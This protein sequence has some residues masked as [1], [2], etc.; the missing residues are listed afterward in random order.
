M[1]EAKKKEDKTEVSKQAER[2]ITVK[3]RRKSQLPRKVDYLLPIRRKKEVTIAEREERRAKERGD[4]LKI[5][6][7]TMK[8]EEEELERMRMEITFVE[9]ISPLFRR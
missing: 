9:Q 7:A 8:K 4:R 6:E 5:A 1:R 3:S 2:R